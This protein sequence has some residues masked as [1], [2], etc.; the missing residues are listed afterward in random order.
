MFVTVVGREEN[1]AILGSSRA[2]V[3]GGGVW[4]Q[5]VIFVFV[6]LAGI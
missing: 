2:R 6:P 1:Q 3:R 5:V 4:I